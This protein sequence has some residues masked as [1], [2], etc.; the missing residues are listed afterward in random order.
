M[1]DF[2]TVRP[3]NGGYIVTAVVALESREEEYVFTSLVG[4]FGF[5]AEEMGASVDLALTP[6]GSDDG[7]SSDSEGVPA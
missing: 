7:A 6:R 3:A 5:L 1:P 4:A 2:W